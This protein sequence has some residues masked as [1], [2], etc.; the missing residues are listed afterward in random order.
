VGALPSQRFWYL[1]GTQTVRG[2]RPGREA[3]NAFW[4]ARAEVAQGVGVIR[5][6]IFSDFGWAGDRR[7]LGNI[8]IPMSGVGAGFSVMDGLLRFDVA[9][10]LNPDRQW[11]VDSY[12]EAR[13]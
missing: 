13:F 2:E 3:G 4:L 9:R 11:R 6:V 5:P 8:G 7:K 10:G 12:I 1:G